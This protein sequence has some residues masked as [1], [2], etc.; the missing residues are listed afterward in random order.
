MN[1]TATELLQKIESKTATVG[2][3]GLGDLEVGA[4]G[5]HEQQAVLDRRRATRRRSWM[6]PAGTV[7]VGVGVE[8]L[9]AVRAEN[10][11]PG[12]VVAV[13]VSRR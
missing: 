12:M 5:V 11:D 4:G 8:A 7:R 3:V 10:I 6:Q 2:I 1:A 9:P 13:V